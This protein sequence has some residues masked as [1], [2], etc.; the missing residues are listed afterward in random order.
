MGIVKTLLITIAN[1]TVAW[2]EQLGTADVSRRS[3]LWWQKAEDQYNTAGEI[4]RQGKEVGKVGR[5]PWMKAPR[6]VVG[7]PC[8]NST[9]PS[10]YASSSEHSAIIIV[11]VKVRAE[12]HEVTHYV[13]TQS[14]GARCG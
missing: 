7:S 13:G 12:R 1:V 5:I 14:W 3:R 9:V 11:S 6:L 4:G 8:E 2:V 10:C